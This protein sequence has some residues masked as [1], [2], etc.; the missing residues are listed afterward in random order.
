MRCL[1]GCGNGDGGVDVS[2]GA[3]LSGAG[4]YCRGLGCG[5]AGSWVQPGKE[6]W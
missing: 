6:K 5:G 2:E 3:N 1:V 4:D